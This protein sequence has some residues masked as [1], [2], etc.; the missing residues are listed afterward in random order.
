MAF[1]VEGADEVGEGPQ[2]PAASFEG[3]VLV[4]VG[5]L[6]GRPAALNNDG[7]HVETT[8]RLK[9]LLDDA[10]SADD[11][12]SEALQGGLDG[13][14]SSL[15]GR[16][17]ELSPEIHGLRDRP[18]CAVFPSVCDGH[19]IPGHRDE[20][21]NVLG[22]HPGDVARPLE[23]PTGDGLHL[24][25]GDG[26]HRDVVLH[27]LQPHA[28]HHRRGVSPAVRR[29]VDDRQAERSSLDPSAKAV[30][31]PVLG[32]DKAPELHARLPE[33]LRRPDEVARAG[34]PLLGWCAQGGAHGDEHLIGRL[35][36][37]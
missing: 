12:P 21:S 17:S 20:G 10:T 18:G 8:L 25:A 9:R 13:G 34:V 4:D 31:A 6:V 30:V 3:H 11:L 16:L 32:C 1:F 26:L 36:G 37:A 35:L 23:R 14:F 33:E 2:P 5:D 7:P 27:P 28:A 19:R 29:D 22:D 24:L 15:L